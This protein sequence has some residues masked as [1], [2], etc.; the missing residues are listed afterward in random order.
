M[1]I[2]FPTHGQ[3]PGFYPGGGGSLLGVLE[4]PGKR[5]VCGC[6]GLSGPVAPNTQADTVQMLAPLP[7][8][9][10][11]DGTP[12]PTTPD[13]VTTP[14]PTVNP[15]TTAVPGAPPGYTDWTQ[16]GKDITAQLSQ[17]PDQT[18]KQVLTQAL[19]VATAAA[20][21]PVVGWVVAAGAAILGLFGIT[22]RGTTQHID[23]TTAANAAYTFVRSRIIPMYQK[24][25]DDA[26]RM[27]AAYT[28]AL[29]AAMVGMFGA[30]W[31][32]GPIAD[33]G[34][35]AVGI[36]AD[37]LLSLGDLSDY[38]NGAT[39]PFVM[40]LYD[41]LR[42]DDAATAQ[43]QIQAQYFGNVESYVLKPLDAY[44]KSKYNQT[45]AQYEAANAAAP[46]SSGLSLTAGMTPLAIGAAGLLAVALTFMGKKKGKRA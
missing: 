37:Y 12:P 3:V 1:R 39:W 22:A 28:A 5:A 24:L 2:M 10:D 42:Y 7:T 33:R 21:I 14:M 13:G 20:G 32:G 40:W 27:F 23:S 34:G 6:D 18:K 17:E 16:A 46:G 36:T 26:K 8:T 29:D 45:V 31:G 15:L 38:M 11:G 41:I 9:P 43:A 44:M 35:L 30:Q 19:G 4:G 25:P